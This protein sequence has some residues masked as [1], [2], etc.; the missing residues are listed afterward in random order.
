MCPV[1]PQSTPNTT[2]RPY[3]IL[4]HFIFPPGQRS[5][6]KYKK[7]IAFYIYGNDY[8][9]NIHGDIVFLRKSHQSERVRKMAKILYYSQLCK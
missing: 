8:A 3:T 2:D 5:V 6:Q 1:W 9:I 4:R 7:K